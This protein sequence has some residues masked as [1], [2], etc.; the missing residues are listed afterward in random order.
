MKAPNDFLLEN[1]PYGPDFTE[2][3]KE[4][5]KSCIYK[6]SQD[7]IYFKEVPKQSVHQLQIS[8]ERIKEEA[9]D[10]ET[11]FVLIDLTEAT[12]PPSDVR[13][14]L[15]KN[16]TELAPNLKYSGVFTGKS[17]LLN[18]AAKFVLSAALGDKFSVHKTKEE[19]LNAIE[20]ARNKN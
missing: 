13:Q 7:I 18:I 12:P 16:F 1:R 11:Y 8:F 14:F 15:S 3:E 5:I 2:E 4:A 9:K 20:N 17:F 6:H 19:A 10:L